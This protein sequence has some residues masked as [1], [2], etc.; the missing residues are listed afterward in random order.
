MLKCYTIS[1]ERKEALEVKYFYRYSEYY[2][3]YDDIGYSAAQINSNLWS[4]AG[5]NRAVYVSKEV[6]ADNEHFK[7]VELTEAEAFKAAGMDDEYTIPVLYNGYPCDGLIFV[8]EERAKRIGKTS[9]LG[10]ISQGAAVVEGS[11]YRDE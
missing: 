10:A 1:I 9:I 3:R 7:H 5:T 8:T 4:M 6:P 11:P 2:K